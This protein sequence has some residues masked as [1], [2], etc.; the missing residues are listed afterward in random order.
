MLDRILK[1]WPVKVTIFEKRRTGYIPI[2]DKARMVNEKGKRYYQ[3]KKKNV[4]IA[5]MDLKHLDYVSGKNRLFLVSPK[6]D[7]Y[8]PLRI[9]DLVIVEDETG[10]EKYGEV[11]IIDEDIRFWDRLQQKE[12]MVKYTEKS[13]I[14]KFMP[15]ILIFS[16]A[17]ALA[18]IFYA[19]IGQ[20]AIVNE[21][22]LEVADKLGAVAAKVPATQAQQATPPPY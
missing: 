4:K 10:E 7:V 12:A 15:I 21:G 20:L 6:R 19:A 9:N 8:L 14:E 13:T 11:R 16:V 3:L 1:P 5:P 17:I 18:I 22:L 2:D